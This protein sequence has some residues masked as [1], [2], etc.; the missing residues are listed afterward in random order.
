[1][2]DDV[3]LWDA[4]ESAQLRPAIEAIGGLEA[5]VAEGGGNFSVGER[6]LICLARAVLRPT[7]MLVLDEA[8]ANVD[9]ET[10]RVIQAVLRD[11]F[12][13]CTVLTIAHRLNTVMDSDF[14][15]VLDNGKVVEFAPPGELFA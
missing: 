12:A 2:G 7:Q 1:M 11:R 9:F 14:M 3:A 15:L 6:Q 13:N 8:T 10:D 4:L 5:K